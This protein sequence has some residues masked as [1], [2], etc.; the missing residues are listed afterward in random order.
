MSFGK[1]IIIK[2]LP[3][4]RLNHCLSGARLLAKSAFTYSNASEGARVSGA[5]LRLQ[6]TVSQTVL[7]TILSIFAFIKRI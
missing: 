3:K 7:K 2:L 1:F 5:S 4:G 6:Q